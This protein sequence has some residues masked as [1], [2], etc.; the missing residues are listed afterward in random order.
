MKNSNNTIGNRSRDLP[1]CSAV[2]QPLRHSVRN[3]KYITMEYINKNK[4]F[5][6]LDCTLCVII[7]SRPVNRA[8]WQRC[9]TFFWRERGRG[10]MLPGG[11][12][13]NSVQFEMDSWTGAQRRLVSRLRSYHSV[14]T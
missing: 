8:I 9:W 10:M 2:P 14:C 1:V 6:V 4:K 3:I 11:V 13:V 12:A 7:Q 5:T